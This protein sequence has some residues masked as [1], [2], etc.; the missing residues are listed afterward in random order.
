MTK[1][2]AMEMFPLLPEQF[3]GEELTSRFRALCKEKH[4]DRGGSH[5]AFV[6][7]QGAYE[8]LLKHTINDE[9][10]TTVDG[11][12][13]SDLGRGLEVSARPCERCNGKGYNIEKIMKTERVRCSCGSGDVC[14]RCRG[15]GLF[16]NKGKCFRCK[17][18]GHIYHRCLKCFGSGF[19]YKETE[20]GEE[21]L[22][23]GFCDGTGEI[24]LLN[25][26]I[27]KNSFI[28]RGR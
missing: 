25:P 10:K 3:T 9:E 15:T 7:L 8:E 2:Q 22:R 12:R 24:E 5:E 21:Y 13:L 16:G 28:R 20:K 14:Q 23:C 1:D 4:P 19:A 11:Y 17:G 26:V 27:P 18:R 6:R